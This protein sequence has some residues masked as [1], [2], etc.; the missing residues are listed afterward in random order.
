MFFELNIRKMFIVLL[1]VINIAFCNV[2]LPVY[3]SDNQYNP[4]DIIGNIYTTD[5][6]AYID[7]MPINSFNIGGRTIIAI[8]DLREYGFNVE[9]D[10][11]AR[12]LRADIG[13]VS[14]Q[15][16]DVSVER[17]AP[18]NICGN[19]Y[20]SD[21]AVEW[22]G[23]KYYGDSYNIGGITCIAIE[24]L[25]ADITVA[26]GYSEYAA[27]YKWDSDERTIMLNVL[28]PGEMLSTPYGAG[29]VTGFYSNYN[30]A[31]YSIEE[32]GDYDFSM[33]DVYNEDWQNYIPISDIPMKWGIDVY[34]GD[35]KC[36]IQSNA[37][38]SIIFYH[39]GS[40]GHPYQVSAPLVG[41][42]IPVEIN[43][44][45]ITP[46]QTNFIAALPLSEENICLNIGF[47]QEITKR[48]VYIDGTE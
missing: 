47:L 9:W 39:W 16:P 1:A 33:Y 42:K 46:S 26:D 40:Y 4:G 3:S 30:K 31:M 14:Q 38:D 27:Y 15:R 13:Q 36:V 7:N 41:L 48:S 19:I 44:Q 43:G 37:S 11:A 5:I 12:T 45:H 23:A 6:I 10:S 34:G 28:R 20:F 22:N 18:G 32:E 17:K 35:N 2:N 21:I 29:E 24:D 25:G 8:E